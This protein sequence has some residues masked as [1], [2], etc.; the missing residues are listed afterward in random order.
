[1]KK[2]EKI[3]AFEGINTDVLTGNKKNKEMVKLFQQ[4]MTYKEI[5]TRY[6]LST[7]R[8]GQILDRQARR[9]IY[10]KNL[11]KDQEYQEL[12]DRYVGMLKR[13]EIIKINKDRKDKINHKMAVN[14][15]RLRN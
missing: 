8:I 6:G 4:G 3:A 7:S 12:V 9:A 13:E 10:Y 2:N 14:E 11:A 15:A 1:L 5:A